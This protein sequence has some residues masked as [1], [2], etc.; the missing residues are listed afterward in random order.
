MNW[1]GRLAV[2]V[3]GL[4]AL[5]WF[6]SRG[7]DQGVSQSAF[8]GTN[9]SEVGAQVPEQVELVG[10]PDV[11]KSKETRQVIVENRASKPV[12]KVALT[13]LPSGSEIR[14][15]E[16]VVKLAE[17]TPTDERLQVTASGRKFPGLGD[18]RK[19]RVPVGVD[20]RFRVAVAAATKTVRF[21]LQ[22]RYNRLNGQVN[23]KVSSKDGPLL[24]AKLGFLLVVQVQTDPASPG[25]ISGF[26]ARGGF[27][28]HTL[29]DR[30]LRLDE[31]QRFELGGLN[32]GSRTTIHMVADG[33]APRTL[34]VTG[35]LPGERE[36]REVVLS[37]GAR[38]SGRIVDQHGVGMQNGAIRAS[39]STEIGTSP[40]QFPV[41]RKAVVMVGTSRVPNSEIIPSRIQNGHF[42]AWAIPAGEVQLNYIGAGLSAMPLEVGEL[43]PGEE[44]EGIEWVVHRQKRIRGH[45][46]WDGGKPAAGALVEIVGNQKRAGQLVQLDGSSTGGSSYSCIADKDGEFV[47]YGFPDEG[48]VELMATGL[49]SGKVPVHLDLD[50]ARV[51]KGP[52][53]SVRQTGIPIGDESVSLTLSES[54]RL[55]GRVVDSFDKPVVSYRLKLRPMGSR[56]RDQ[57]GRILQS[58]NPVTRNIS[59][60]EGRFDLGGIAAGK[61]QIDVRAKGYQKFHPVSQVIPHT[62]ELI[63]KLSREARIHGRVFSADGGGVKAEV[64]I[65]KRQEDGRFA[66]QGAVSSLAKTGFRIARLAAGTYSLRAS[67]P[68]H[69][70]SKAITIRVGDGEVLE[71][72]VL[73]L[74][75]PGAIR[76]TV[77]RDWWQ[78][79]LWIKMSALR[80]LKPKRRSVEVQPNGQFEIQG[81]A[82]GKHRIELRFDGNRGLAHPDTRTVEVFP[83]QTTTLNF[84]PAADGSVRLSGRLLSGGRGVSGRTLTFVGIEP[85]QAQ[86]G[87]RTLVD[88]KYSVTLAGGGTFSVRC[89]GA[90]NRREIHWTETIGDEGAQVLDM[91]LPEGKLTLKFVTESGARIPEWVEFNACRLRRTHSGR[92]IVIPVEHGPGQVTFDSLAPGAYTIELRPL[93]DYILD[94]STNEW[95]ILGSRTQSIEFPGEQRTVTI[96]VGAPSTLMGQVSGIPPGKSVK[97]LVSRPGSPPERIEALEVRNGSFMAR[98]LPGSPVSVQCMNSKGELG[99][100]IS[101]ALRSGEESQINL[102]YPEEWR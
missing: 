53:W 73:R 39:V 51:R 8:K 71:D 80:E 101:V 34:T 78:P 56:P 40:V 41:A 25:A 66:G 82:A 36:E 91:S 46:F 31:A 17:G 98:N 87:C 14:W 67:H 86:V 38:L 23:W 88:G 26:R 5:L 47:L 84:G 16:G 57:G 24:Q 49:T 21:T 63:L 85:H 18:R 35:A 32:P 93:S 4:G 6:A 97:V 1:V 33:Y 62:G 90:P 79:G 59:D 10:V 19:H 69:G 83:G 74:P 9:V 99:E 61:W 81:I 60:P 27:Q 50:A 43:K 70:T 76:G 15:I 100:A 7:A 11:E 96:K 55:V 22:G 94:G 29:E 2:M 64:A 12:A 95:V 13:S 72:V 65:S 52:C 89:S 58:S 75:T 30:E 42:V 28:S 54:P 3:V 37:R 92:G 102:T 68:E 45:V 77:H 20:G 48:T 44:R